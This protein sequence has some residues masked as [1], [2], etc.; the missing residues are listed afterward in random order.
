MSVCVFTG[1]AHK[2]VEQ[3]EVKGED[4]LVLGCGP[5]GLF[6]IAIAKALGEFI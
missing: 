3:L 2:A 4:V 1:V 6:S 5:V